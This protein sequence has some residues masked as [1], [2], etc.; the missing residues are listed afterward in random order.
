LLTGNATAAEAEKLV[1]GLPQQL[2]SDPEVLPRHPVLS[3]A[4]VPEGKATVM[5]EDS[6]DAGSRVAA[7]EMYWQLGLEGEEDFKQRAVLDLLEAIMSEPLFDAL[8]TKQQLG[9]VA[10]CGVRIT[11]RVYGYSIWLLSSKVGPAEICRRVE[12]FLPEFRQRLVDLPAEDFE[13]HATSLAAQKLEP[14][15]TLLSVQEGAWSELQD[16]RSVFDRYLREAVALSTVARADLL[17]V[18]DRCLLPGAAERRLLVVAVIGGRAKAKKAAEL[19]TFQSDYPGCWHV[20]SQADFLAGTTLLE[21][22]N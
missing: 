3:V 5:V 2:R 6:P 15:R 7:V 22:V 8:R 1:Q 19:K 11:Q 17:E 14:D 16:R 12:A 9:Y 10:S 18:L 13:R 20:S 4:R 21:D